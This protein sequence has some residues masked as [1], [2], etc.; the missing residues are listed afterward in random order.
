MISPE[1][2]ENIARLLSSTN[3]ADQRNGIIIAHSF[4]MKPIEMVKLFL[5]WGS[6]WEYEYEN[7]RGFDCLDC[8]KTLLGNSFT[9]LYTFINHKGQLEFTTYLNRNQLRYSK[10]PPTGIKHRSSPMGKLVRCLLRL[11]DRELKTY[12]V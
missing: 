4:G 12:Q 6:G 9:M 5:N 3:S 10:K 1:E 7:F 8:Q 2:T 11:I